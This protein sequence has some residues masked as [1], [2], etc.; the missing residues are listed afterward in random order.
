ML[1]RL[2]LTSRLVLLAL[3]VVAPQM[4]TARLF[5]KHPGYIHAMSDLRYARY[6][7]ARPDQPNVDNDENN[8]VREIDACL[9]D[10]TRASINDGKNPNDHPWPDLGIDFK[11]R[12]HKAVDALNKAYH[13]MDKE[14]D[15]PY[16]R[17]LQQRAVAHV[18]RAR[19]FVKKAIHDKYKDML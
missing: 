9:N 13:D 18:E 11:G 2:C 16:N 4:A 19:A 8:A 15:D 7:V 5:E 12:L 17:G 10:L 14:E 3:S 6:L 1:K